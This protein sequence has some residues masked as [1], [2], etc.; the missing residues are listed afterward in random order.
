MTICGWDKLMNA[1]DDM[2]RPMMNWFGD[3]LDWLTYG[4]WTSDWYVMWQVSICNYKLGLVLFFL[5]GTEKK[6]KLGLGIEV[7]ASDSVVADKLH[8]CSRL[9]LI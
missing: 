9:N 3:W 8:G 1:D 4:Y 5:V 7:G 2:Y 6:T